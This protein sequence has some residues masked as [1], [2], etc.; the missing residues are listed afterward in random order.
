MLILLL[1]S[2]GA[3][4]GAQL[5]DYAQIDAIFINS[6]NWMDVYSGVLLGK[7]VNK[8]VFFL[9]DESTAPFIIDGIPPQIETVLL[10]EPTNGKVYSSASAVL[11]SKGKTIAGYI[12]DNINEEVLDLIDVD[13]LILVDDAYGYDAM[14]VAPYAVLTDSYV[15]FVND[16]DLKEDLTSGK[17][18]ILYGDLDRNVQDAYENL[19]AMSINEGGRFD[20]NIMIVKEFM[21]IKDTRQVTFSNGEF[22]ERSLFSD[23][24][25]LL[26]IGKTSVPPQTEEFIAQ[27]D[28]TIATLVGNDLSSLASQL[29]RRLLTSYGKEFGVMLMVGK[30][31]TAQGSGE[32]VIQVLDMFPIPV[33]SAALDIESIVFNQVTDM[34]EI[35][36]RNPGVLKTYFIPSLSLD[37]GTVLEGSE[38]IVFID[39]EKSKTI[40]YKVEGVDADTSGQISALFGGTPTELEAQLTFSFE[41]LE[42]VSIEDSSSLDIISL[43]FDP[44]L[45]A[46]LVE[47]QNTGRVDLYASI[48]LIDVILNGETVSLTANKNLKLAAGQIETVRIRAKLDALDREE[49][50]DVTVKAYYGQREQVL[51]KT[52]EK[53]L[54][55][56]G[57]LPMGVIVSLVAI[58]AIVIMLLLFFMKKKKRRHHGHHHKA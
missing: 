51:F 18:L 32:T 39:G 44:L 17:Q 16:E 10:L 22:I 34:L 36:F 55:V 24:A 30:S 54:P 12:R 58:V 11:Q 23:L 41:N 8:Q 3:V 48:E 29:K 1:C 13:S 57:T 28:L 26:F 50:T 56:E 7:L 40:T 2:I 20:N 47:V 38:D 43:K 35:T 15:L 25:P 21:K 9:I 5:Q 19:A 53:T 49:N 45:N 27:S 33:Y 31:S 46:F 14:S 42:T 4:Y 52:L 37:A 6:E